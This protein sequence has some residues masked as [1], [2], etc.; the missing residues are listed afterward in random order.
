[1][2]H[3]LLLVLVSKDSDHW[4]GWELLPDPPDYSHVGVIVSDAGPIPFQ[5]HYQLVE[6]SSPF[7]VLDLDTRQVR[8]V[9]WG[10]EC[11]R[12]EF[13]GEQSQLTGSNQPLQ[14]LLHILLLESIS[15]RVVSVDHK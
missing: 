11:L 12:E 2:D 15:I 1:M 9:Y 4:D 7:S 5:E 14:G 6:L 8:Q 10:L 3:H 13:R